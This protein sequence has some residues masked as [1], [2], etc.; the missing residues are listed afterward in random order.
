[1]GREVLQE[2]GSGM[3]SRLFGVRLQQVPFSL[4]PSMPKEKAEGGEEGSF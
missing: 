4:P 2:L 1:M 3:G